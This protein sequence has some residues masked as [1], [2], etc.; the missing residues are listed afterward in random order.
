MKAL[1]E[2]GWGGVD[3]MKGPRTKCHRLERERERKVS[4][5]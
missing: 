3:E 1:V 5:N 2:E 4:T